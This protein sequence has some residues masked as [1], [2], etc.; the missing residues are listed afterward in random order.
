MRTLLEPGT[1]DVRETE[2]ETLECVPDPD[3]VYTLR[4]LSVAV[5][6]EIGKRHTRLEFD[7]KTH[8][9]VEIVNGEAVN[10]DVVDYIIAGWTGIAGDVPCTKE[11]K[12]KLPVPV[13]KA[14]LER[15]QV[16]EGSAEARAASFRES[17]TVV[18]VLG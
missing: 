13:Q 17:Q 5:A 10:D 8:R 14:L 7:P 4:S 6:R 18:S 15:A 3:A 12:L 11:N 16:G 9:K 1:F 2:L